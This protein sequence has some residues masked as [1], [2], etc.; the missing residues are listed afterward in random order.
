MSNGH[1]VAVSGGFDPLHVGH[2]RYFLAAK[3]IAPIL[4]VILNG[5]SFLMRKKG[6]MFMPM[7]ERAEIIRNIRCVDCVWPFKSET[8]NVAEAIRVIKPDF[9]AKAG[10]RNIS[11]IPSEEIEACREVGCEIKDN[12]ESSYQK[13]SSLLV[14]EAAERLAWGVYS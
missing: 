10:D 14:K 6:Y 11:N 13:H 7:E 8:D 5:D 1:I 2:I 12:L 4:I 9:F 3:K